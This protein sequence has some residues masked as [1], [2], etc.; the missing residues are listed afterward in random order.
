MGGFL[1]FLPT[2]VLQPRWALCQMLAVNVP[3]GMQSSEGGDMVD[4]LSSFLTPCWDV[5]PTGSPGALSWGNA[6]INVPYVNPGPGSRAQGLMGAVEVSAVQAWS[7]R[8]LL[9]TVDNW[10]P[11]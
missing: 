11:S 1:D 2:C 8:A 10:T 9:T 5:S 7:H 4:T 6:F 3:R